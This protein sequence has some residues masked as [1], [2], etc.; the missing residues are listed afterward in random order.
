MPGMP[1]S[2]LELAILESHLS[3]SNKTFD[4]LLMI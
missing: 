3:E 4:K 1:W 2:E